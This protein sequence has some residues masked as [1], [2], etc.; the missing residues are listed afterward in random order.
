M[1]TTNKSRTNQKKKKNEENSSEGE[2][3]SRLV[4]YVRRSR[5]GHGLRVSINSEA[6]QACH[7]Y[8]TSDGQSYVP[9]V[10]SVAAL[11]RVMDGERAVTALSQ[12]G[13]APRN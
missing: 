8:E 2:D 12:L 5:S 10:L 11:R 6:F 9:L 3:A 13:S 7:T 4:G 1:N